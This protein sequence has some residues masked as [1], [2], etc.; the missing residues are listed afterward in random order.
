MM[1]CISEL[2]KAFHYSST[3]VKT[4]IMAERRSEVL[5]LLESEKKKLKSLQQAKRRIIEVVIKKQQE[6]QKTNDKINECKVKLRAFR[7][8]VHVSQ[9][10]RDTAEEIEQFIRDTNVPD[11]IPDHEFMDANP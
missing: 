4:S 11:L 8:R 9:E 5:E 1:R 2:N 3:E 6:L 7:Q 10:D